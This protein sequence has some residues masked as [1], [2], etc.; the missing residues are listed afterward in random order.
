MKILI[1][2][3]HRTGS[4]SLANFLVYHY[5]DSDYI[6]NIDINEIKNIDNRII[7]FTPNEMPYESIYKLF[8]KRIILI[9]EN[10][11][12]QAESRLYA[13][14]VEKKFSDYTIPKEFLQK[15]SKE[16]EDLQI[17]IEEENLYLKSCKDCLQITYEEL[18]FSYEG[19]RKLEEYL[20]IEFKF[21]LDNRKRYRNGTKT[22]I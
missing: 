14:L 19:V 15:Y 1:Y 6:R 22:L 16:I 2:T 20:G 17:K 10:K 12:E 9:R 5:P 13:D 8:D 21:M 4:T 3:T 7:K 18:F 11:K